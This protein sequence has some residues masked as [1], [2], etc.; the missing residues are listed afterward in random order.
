[1]ILAVEDGDQT[2]GCIQSEG[3][4]LRKGCEGSIGTRRCGN[5]V[6]YIITDR[7]CGGRRMCSSIF[8]TAKLTSLS[9]S[10]SSCKSANTS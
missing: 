7:F 4:K 5:L 8:E 6:I 10:N 9:R 2:A 1:L 3:A